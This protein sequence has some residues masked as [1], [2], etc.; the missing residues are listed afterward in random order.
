[1]DP[2]EGLNGEIS[3]SLFSKGNESAEESS[4]FGIDS[5]TGR[6]FS[7]S[8]ME[9]ESGRLLD[10]TVLATDLKGSN[11]GKSSPFH[12]SVMSHYYR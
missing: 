10:Y 2:D 4:L 8:S 5:V 11:N 9:H 1:M 3:Y 7:T 6:I 12:L